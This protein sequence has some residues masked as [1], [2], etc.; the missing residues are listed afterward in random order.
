MPDQESNLLPRNTTNMCS[1]GN[2]TNNFG[3]LPGN[4]INTYVPYK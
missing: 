2:E 4:Y 1:T 3:F